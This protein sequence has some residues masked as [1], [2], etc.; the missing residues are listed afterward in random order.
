MLF[1]ATISSQV[2][3]FTLSGMKDYR[4]VQVDRDSKLSEF[5]KLHFYI[6]RSGE[7]EAALFYILRER[8]LANQQTIVFCA[9]KYHIEYLH[10]LCTLAGFSTD[11][12]YGSMDQRTRED[13]MFRFRKKFTR[14]L[15]VTD[16][17]ARG[18]DIPLLENVVHYDS[19]TKMKLFIH[20]AGRTARAGQSGTECLIRLN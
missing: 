19:P 14:V 13:R 16:L 11:F 8:V 10:E 3:D 15:L 18:I 9:T 1:S 2:K 7:K 20:R 4:M 12:I 17:A 5:L 6:V